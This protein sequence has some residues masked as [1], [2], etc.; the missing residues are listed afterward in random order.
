M[1]DVGSENMNLEF[2]ANGS[3]SDIKIFALKVNVKQFFGD[4]FSN[5]PPFSVT[6][7]TFIRLRALT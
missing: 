2:V 5:F 1:V 6:I 7:P 3:M 4:H